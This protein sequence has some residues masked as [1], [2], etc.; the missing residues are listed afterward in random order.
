MIGRVLR[1]LLSPLEE[2]RDP[3]AAASGIRRLSM[4]RVSIAAFTATVCVRLLR[5]DVPA[6]TWPEFAVVA[7]VLFA[8][9]VA[10]FLDSEGLKQLVDVLKRLATRKEDTP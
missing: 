10:K 5:P 6:M 8:V 7:A 3:T 4:L 1:Y 2:K 9:P